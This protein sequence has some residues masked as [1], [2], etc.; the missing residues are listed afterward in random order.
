MPSIPIVYTCRPTSGY[1][2]TGDPAPPLEGGCFL[3][4]NDNFDQG[5]RTRLRT[6]VEREQGNLLSIDTACVL[7]CRDEF[8]SDFAAIKFTEVKMPADVNLT[9]L[10]K[11]MI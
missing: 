9:F 10:S 6:R 11:L 7:E 3:R 5:S 4:G 8:N 2:F 1:L